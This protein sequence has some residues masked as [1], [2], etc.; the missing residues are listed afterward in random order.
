M[1]RSCELEIVW[2]AR[3]RVVI[4]CDHIGEYDV[5]GVGDEEEATFSIGCH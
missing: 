4:F 2:Q 1:Y 3:W 5:S